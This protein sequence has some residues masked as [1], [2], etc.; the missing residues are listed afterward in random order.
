MAASTPPVFKLTDA[1]K[2]FSE[3]SDAA[4]TVLDAQQR[5]DGLERQVADAEA[6]AL[7]ATLDAERQAASAEQKIE[8]I[9][10]DLA[11]KQDALV[12]TRQQIEDGTRQ[13]NIVKKDYDDLTARYA[14]LREL[15][16]KM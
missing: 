7:T 3:F 4:N 11:A 9:N 6:R 12:V 1:A 5:L 13:R 15:V 8:K 2:L 10:A 16:T 14:A